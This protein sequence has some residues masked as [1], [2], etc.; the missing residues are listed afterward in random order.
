MSNED[1][2]EDFDMFR[3]VLEKPNIH[4]KNKVDHSAHA[5]ADLIAPQA[6]RHETNKKMRPFE[7]VEQF[8]IT[9]ENMDRADEDSRAKHVQ[10]LDPI[11]VQQ[12]IAASIDEQLDLSSSK[13]HPPGGRGGGGRPP[14]TPMGPAGR[15]GGAGGHDKPPPRGPDTDGDGLRNQGGGVP[16]PVPLGGDSSGMSNVARDLASQLDLSDISDTAMAKMQREVLLEMLREPPGEN[17]ARNA[18]I[19][20]MNEAARD[21][22]ENATFAD[23]QAYIKRI[24]KER[25]K[26]RVHATAG[27]AKEKEEAESSSS[28]SEEP[29][30]PDPNKTQM[31]NSKESMH[32]D[33]VKFKTP[34]R[35]A[36][37]AE[38]IKHCVRLS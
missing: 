25:A 26:E 32:T 23:I 9:R 16:P 14:D 8:P 35:A 30:T 10:A 3:Q 31:E 33:E 37:I 27:T 12:N 38:V 29:V 17:P 18:M 21:L 1:Y 20:A 34:H 13:R 4:G 36:K 15:G 28:L 7:G 11:K 24:H 22:P 19:A 2:L 5:Y 6:L